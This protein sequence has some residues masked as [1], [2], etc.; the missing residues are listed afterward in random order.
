MPDDQLDPARPL[1]S[2]LTPSFGQARWLADNLVS[3]ERQT[4]ANI[5]HIVADGGSVDGSIEILERHARPGLRWTSDP[6]RGQSHAINKAFALSR[7]E[8]IGWLNSDDAYF[9]AEAVADAVEI[10][11]TD[12]RVTVVYGHAVLVNADGLLLQVM[13]TPPF[14]RR[15]LRLHDFISQPTAFIR[16][17]ALGDELVDEAYDYMMDYELW[18]R[19][20]RRGRFRR[21]DSIVAID[22]HQLARKSY[23][24]ADIGRQDHDRLRN[25]YRVAGGPI[26]LVARKTWKI[27]AR[28][29]GASLVATASDQGVAVPIVR[30]GRSR[31]L[32]RQLITPRA[33][34]R[35]GSETRG[36]DN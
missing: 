19:L 11:A 8:I 27:V 26:A 14:S 22:R 18:L 15:L 7:G 25:T 1:V 20:A 35:S 33:V 16:R 9:G 6:D 17:S 23:T 21:I 10:F 12:P 13:W 36:S 2:V 29:A 31:L 5:E 3:V 24:M 28:L 4:Y 32:V 34:M 30:D